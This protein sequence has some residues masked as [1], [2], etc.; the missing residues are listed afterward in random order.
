MSAIL[1]A[2][3]ISLGLV[4][5]ALPRLPDLSSDLA[6]PGELSRYRNWLPL[7]KEPRAVSIGAWALCRDP[8]AAEVQERGGPHARHRIMV[9][10]NA[11][12][13][14]GLS[15]FGVFE[16]GAIIA[17]EKL[18]GAD[19]ALPKGVAFMVKRGTPSF[20]ASGGWEFLYYPRA[21][22]P[23]DAQLTHE[24]CAACHRRGVGRDYVLGEYENGIAGAMPQNK[25]LQR[26]LP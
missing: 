12:A 5:G 6:L 16:T 17:K 3:A 4:T 11:I 8:T 24:H 2:L 19:H 15:A 25:Q 10:G 14:D 20:E 22:Y 1:K 7:L 13:V 26:G 18:S 21:S 23:A 9:Y